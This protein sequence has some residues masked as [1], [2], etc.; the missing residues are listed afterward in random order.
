MAFPVWNNPINKRQDFTEVDYP[1]GTGARL[2]KY[3]PGTGEN[4]SFYPNTGC[5][6][7]GLISYPLTTSL[8]RLIK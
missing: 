3:P 2:Q 8:P 4:L 7:P 5:P 6:S 1:A